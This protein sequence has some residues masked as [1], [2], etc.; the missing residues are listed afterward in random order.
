MSLIFILFY[1]YSIFVAIYDASAIEYIANR[2]NKSG[3]G[4]SGRLVRISRF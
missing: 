1:F 3:N 4:A 2:L